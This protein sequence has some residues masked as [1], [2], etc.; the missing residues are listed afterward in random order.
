MVSAP[1]RNRKRAVFFERNSSTPA[2]LRKRAEVFVFTLMNQSIVLDLFQQQ[3]VDAIR[4]GRSVLL[5]APTGAGKTLVAETAIE[6]SLRKNAS[7]IYTAP[8]KA[9]SNQKYRDFRERFGES[10]VGILTGD[11]AIRPD[12]PI[13]IMTTEIYRNSLFEDSARIR[14]MSWIIFD[15]I[16]YLDDPERGTVWEEAILF[17]PPQAKI[18]ALSATVP[19]ISQIG[20]WIRS[21]RPE[22]DLTVIESAERPVP[23][24]FLFQCQGLIMP[25]MRELQRSGYLHK[26]H[27]RFDPRERKRGNK[28]M[29]A[30]PNRLDHLLSHLL[31]TDRLPAIHFVFGRRQAEYL[32]W[33]AVRFNL[34]S[35]PEKEKISKLY[36]DLL[37]RY[38]ITRE[39]SAQDL[40]PL[41][42]QGIGYHHA[43]MLPTLKEV[44]E[45]LFTSRLMKLIFT[46]ETFALG[47]NM[48]ARTV[49][50]DELSKF[51]G[52]G[53][54]NLTT[55]DFYQMAGRAGRRGMDPEG[56]VYSRV[57][58]HDIAYS[59]IQRMLFGKPEAIRSQ[60]NTTYATL[61]HLYEDL[62]TGLFEIFPKS[63]YY[64][65]YDER[66]R[67]KGLCLMQQKI[68]LLGDMGYLNDAGLTDKGRFAS[69]LFGYE[70]IM[71]E[72]RAAGILDELSPADLA[73]LLSS[74]IY[75]PRK[76]QPTSLRLKPRHEKLRKLADHH[77][78]WIYRKELKFRIPARHRI[79]HF[80]LAGMVEAW[81]HGA[82][83]QK[84]SGETPVDE[85]EL[86]RYLRMVIQLLRE[87]SHSPYVDKT[88]KESARSAEQK[89]NRD[90]VDAEQ[91]LR[92]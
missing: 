1:G 16:H 24:H 86:I 21:I 66:R 43:G 49:I 25:S 39:R 57:N 61:L 54:R 11:V 48:P 51:Y 73:A 34:L 69:T 85:G 18:L 91:Q 89:I 46:T 5:S 23:L 53:F 2:C 45:Q 71:T 17:T 90:I 6:E 38:G 75:E 27:W 3:A 50:F 68:R 63:F 35:A 72:M 74:F 52:T 58:P 65:Q 83:F 42:E 7:A 79:S 62:G 10:S 81:V 12:A 22:M 40:F 77:L 84:L 9:L 8:I 4:G 60:L 29:R 47:I 31:E 37:E 20:D 88:L 80:H 70:L 41:I 64:F 13:L 32:A 67:S 14:H 36:S 44:V 28:P 82:S 55:R 30:K 15:E 19:N 87:L 59:E 76:G 56:F 33:E 92:V 78:E 26:D